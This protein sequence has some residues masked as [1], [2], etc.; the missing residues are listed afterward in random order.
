[1]T[2]NEQR[3]LTRMA[4][5]ARNTRPW[6]WTSPLFDP[7]HGLLPLHER[8]SRY[9]ESDSGSGPMPWSDFRIRTAAQAS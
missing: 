6:C 1:M 3:L 8:A 4:T 7:K 5:E 9:A 2:E